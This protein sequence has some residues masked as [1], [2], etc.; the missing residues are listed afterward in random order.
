MGAGKPGTSLLLHPGEQERQRQLG[1]REGRHTRGILEVASRERGDWLVRIVCLEREE[2]SRPEA[3]FWL[4]V[5][6][7]RNWLVVYPRA[8]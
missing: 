5:P 7:F 2:A 4:R 8:G 3:G 6:G 1:W